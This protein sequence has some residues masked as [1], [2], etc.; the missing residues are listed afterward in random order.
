M[1]WVLLKNLMELGTGWAIFWDGLLGKKK[2]LKNIWC[3][4]WEKGKENSG[5]KSDEKARLW[6]ARNFAI[7]NYLLE[8]WFIALMFFFSPFVPLWRNRLIYRELRLP[9]VPGKSKQI[10]LFP[11]NNKQNLGFIV[12]LFQGAQGEAILSPNSSQIVKSL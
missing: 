9:Q 8:H 2:G 10:C 5:G 6:W 4:S 3:L 1:Y 12:F 11:V 7:R